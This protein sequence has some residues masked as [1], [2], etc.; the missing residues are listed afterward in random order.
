MLYKWYE[1]VP[2]A[3]NCDNRCAESSSSFFFENIFDKRISLLCTLF[4]VVLSVVVVLQRAVKRRG[5][6][7]KTETKKERD[8][9]REKENNKQKG[10][11]KTHKSI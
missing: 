1:C 6:T 2:D 7:Q 11:T 10:E 8:R 3:A 9:K 5:S 4:Y